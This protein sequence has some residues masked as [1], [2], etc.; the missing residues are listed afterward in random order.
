[1]PRPVPF[2]SFEAGSRPRGTPMTDEAHERRVQRL[3]GRLPGRAL[4][5]AARWLHR[6]AARWVRLPVGLLLVAGGLLWFLPVVG[7]WMLPLGLILL[8]EDVP[9]VRRLT[10]RALAW[11]ERRWPQLFAAPPS[12]PDQSTSEGDHR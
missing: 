8:S 1:M 5:A 12:P 7:L 4:P 11:L 2:A 6:P 9:A 10:S 3:I